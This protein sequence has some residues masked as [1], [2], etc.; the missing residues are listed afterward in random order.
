MPSALKLCFLYL[1]VFPKG[2][3]LDKE[4]LIRQWIALDMIGSKHE[5]LPSYVHGEMYIEDLLSIYFLQ[6]QKTHSVSNEVF[7]R[8][9]V[10]L[11]ML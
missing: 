8:L 5:T 4:K 9:T 6:V 1:S 11:F 10:F 3:L 2:S 7:V